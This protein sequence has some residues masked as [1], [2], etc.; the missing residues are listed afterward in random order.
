MS[1]R[2]NRAAKRNHTTDATRFSEKKWF[3]TYGDQNAMNEIPVSDKTLEALADGLKQWVNDN[4]D[5]YAS[6]RSFFLGMDMSD[7][8]LRYYLKRSEVLRH[9]YDVAVQTFGIRRIKFGCER[10]ID[11]AM[12]RPSQGY[13]EP[14][15]REEQERLSRISKESLASETK[16][17]CIPVMPNT[18]EVPEL[19]TETTIKIAPIG[20][21]ET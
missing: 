16:I 11:T 18:N 7:A 5:E 1:R 8:S 10:K 12:I 17:V 15:L 6:V 19:V 9:A 21:R 20:D 13:Y 2:I 14:E 4:P 3:A